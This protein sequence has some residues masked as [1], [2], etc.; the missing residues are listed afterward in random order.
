MERLRILFLAADPGTR[1]A[2]APRPRFR[3]W[4]IARAQRGQGWQARSAGTLS[5]QMHER[6]VMVVPRKNGYHD[7]MPSFF[8]PC[9]I[10]H[11]TLRTR[12]TLTM[13]A[14]S[15]NLRRPVRPRPHVEHSDA[16]DPNAAPRPAAPC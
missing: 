4:L 6:S 3:R 13:T 10:H 2:Q 9:I 14:R 5:A 7:S 12:R 1:T 16:P 15:G 8:F 11:P